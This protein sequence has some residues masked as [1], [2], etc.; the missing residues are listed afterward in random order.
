MRQPAASPAAT[1]AAGPL[2]RLTAALAETPA[3][4]EFSRSPAAPEGHGAP[5]RASAAAR[6]KIPATPSI[7]DRKRRTDYHFS[8]EPPPRRPTSGKPAQNP[9]AGLGGEAALPATAISRIAT[10]VDTLWVSPAKAPRPAAADSVLQA[11]APSA[12]AAAGE[13]GAAEFGGPHPPMAPAAPWPSAPP[14]AGAAVRRRSED[15]EPEELAEL[16]N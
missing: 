5:P 2:A 6:N 13:A 16:I 9:P 14:E 15:P 7:R 11:P 1:A 8:P 12:F 10:L 4:S 3:G